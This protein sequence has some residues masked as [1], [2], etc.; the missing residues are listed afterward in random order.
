MKIEKKLKA[1]KIR[2]WT[3]DELKGKDREFSDQLFRLK[4]QFASG[5]S[6]V[7]NNL[8]VLR[9]NLARVKTVLREKQV[10]STKAGKS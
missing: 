4:F 8:R 7:L 10:K 2:E 6:D 1:E 5:Q 9:R 3:D